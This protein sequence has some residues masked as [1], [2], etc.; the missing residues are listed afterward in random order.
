[1]AHWDWKLLQKSF[2]W[3][4]WLYILFEKKVFNLYSYAFCRIITAGF[5]SEFSC[6]HYFY[7]LG[8]FISNIWFCKFSIQVNRDLIWAQN[9]NLSF[10]SFSVCYWNLNT[11]SFHKFIKV[12]LLTGCNAIHKFN[13]KGFTIFTE[14]HQ[15]MRHATLLKK[16]SNTGVFLWKLRNF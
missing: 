4:L 13:I 15:I 8:K 12:S 9:L 1:M 16:D 5:S 6:H 14:E 2:E 10:V 3:S 11:R 7:S